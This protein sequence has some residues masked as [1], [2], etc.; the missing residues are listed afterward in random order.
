M[1]IASGMPA[2]ARAE[3]PTSL[4]AQLQQLSSKRVYFGH[5]SVGSNILD[6]LRDL[7]RESK[8]SLPV[9][10]ADEAGKDQPG[11][12][13]AYVGE[14]TRP[15][16]KIA[17]FEKWLA[18]PAANADIA[19]FKFCYVD[20][21]AATDVRALFDS[22]VSMYERVKAGKPHV[23]FVHVT[24]PLTVTQGGLKGY[25][26]KLLG[27]DPAGERENIKRHEFNELLRARFAGKAPIFDLARVESVQPDGSPHGFERDGRTFPSLVPAYSYD[28]EH[29][30]EQGRKHVAAELV[31]VLASIE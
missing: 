27:R 18:D 9:V 2:Q 21:D 5:Q 31:K 22:Y 4:A 11:I 17:G 20:I 29:L 25:V 15:A 10:K 8:V 1:T 14:N 6:G 24:V 26:K 30:N 16:T 23:E 13:H 7:A 12:V 19:F 28:G 3:T